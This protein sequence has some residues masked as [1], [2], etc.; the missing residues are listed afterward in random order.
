[1]MMYAY[2]QILLKIFGIIDCVV[3]V[4]RSFG[5]WI[6]DHSERSL[7]RIRYCLLKG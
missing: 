4:F 5:P 6:T 7:N 2:L 3:R 1:M